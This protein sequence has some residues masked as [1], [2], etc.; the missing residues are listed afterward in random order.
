MFALT[1]PEKKV[2]LFIALVIFLGTLIRFFNLE[3]KDVVL[4]S[5]L[6]EAQPLLIN[7]NQASAEKLQQ[8]PGI[9][10]VIANRIIE[11]RNKKGFFQEAACLKSVKGIG[12]HKLEAIKEYLVF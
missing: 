9:G 7:P 2:L 12:R 10:P 11:H 8:L 5:E 4:V 1:P 3:V 6:T